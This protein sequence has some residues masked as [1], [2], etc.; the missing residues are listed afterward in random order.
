MKHFRLLP[1]LVIACAASVLAQTA[2]DLLNDGKNTANV[3]TQSMGYA[4]Q[5]YSP[6]KQINAS[7]AKCLVPLWT[8]SVMNDMGELAAPVIYN[9]V[10]YVINGKMTFALDVATGRQIWRTPVVLEQGTVGAPIT[11][12]APTIYNGKLFR[13]TYD[14]HLVALD[15]KTGAELWN[16][17]FADKKDGYYATGAP[18]VA[19]GV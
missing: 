9:G 15:M 2:D 3:T 19:N 6:L 17:K 18:I 13:V 14:N 5:S 7:N 12:G 11:R 16:Q 8:T 10:M 1:L 4:R